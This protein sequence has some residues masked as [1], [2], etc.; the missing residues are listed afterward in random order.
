MQAIAY[1]LEARAPFHLGLRGVGLEATAVYASADTVFAALCHALRQQF[2]RDT[3]EDFLRTYQ[4]SPALLLSSAFPYVPVWTEGK[5][6]REKPLSIDP[7]GVIRFYP[8]PLERPPG[9]ADNPRQRKVVKRIRWLSEDIFR[10]WIGEES[11]EQ[12][13]ALIN[14][15][16]DKSAWLTAA[17]RQKVAG[18]RDEEGDQIRLWAQGD[19]PRVTVDRRSN[20]SQVYQAGRVWYQP[21][22][23]L[24]LLAH[25]REDWQERGETALQVLGDAG[26]GGERS[27]GHGQFHLHG[28]HTLPALPNPQP[29]QRFLTLSLYYP[30]PGE[31]SQVLQND[32]VRYQFEMRRGWMSSPDTVQDEQGRTLSGRALRRRAV[33]LFAE[34]SILYWPT[35]GTLL[36]QLADVTPEVFQKVHP[37]WRYGLAFPVGYWGEKEAGDE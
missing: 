4:D 1:H 25:W 29:G 26:L 12:H 6:S 19:V 16:Q 33:R 22:G 31:L 13:F 35:E 11:L 32:D 17:E 7:A 18:W 5:V 2:G 14:L 27:A 3:L 10:T 34:G 28:P 24:W 37:V 9:L 20:A 23:G 21:G 8:R 15:V 30:R 36:G